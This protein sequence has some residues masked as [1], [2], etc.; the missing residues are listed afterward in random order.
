MGQKEHGFRLVAGVRGG[1]VRLE[2]LDEEEEGFEIELP[3][4]VVLEG[5]EDGGG[6]VGGHLEEA[7]VVV[8]DLAAEVEAELEN[9]HPHHSARQLLPLPQL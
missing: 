8:R 2:E 7:G 3:A 1:G 6:E 9:L 4:V 5:L